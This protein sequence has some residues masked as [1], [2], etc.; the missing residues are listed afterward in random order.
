M[1]VLLP[2]FVADKIGFYLLY[3]LNHIELMGE[4]RNKIVSLEDNSVV[5]LYD[6]KM[7]YYDWENSCISSLVASHNIK[8]CDIV[9]FHKHYM[10]RSN[11]D[12]VWIH[13]HFFLRN[14]WIYGFVTLDKYCQ[15]QPRYGNSRKQMQTA[16]RLY[17]K[18][19]TRRH[20]FKHMRV[21]DLP[22]HYW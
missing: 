3:H 10:Y 5:V 20:K 15:S 4:I 13:G 7:R 2:K 9:R 8:D 22:K 21:A 12:L 6:K 11:L 17:I 16:K 19:S 18:L 14:S 1:M